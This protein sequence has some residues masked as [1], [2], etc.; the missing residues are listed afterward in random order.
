MGVY[1]CQSY[2]CG[3][4]Y[5]DVGQSFLSLA[6]AVDHLRVLS[7]ANIDL[8]KIRNPSIDDYEDFVA[9]IR[10]DGEKDCLWRDWSDPR[11]DIFWLEELDFSGSLTEMSS[12]LSEMHEAR[13]S[14]RKR[15]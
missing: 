12:F 11:E 2:A 8:I 9:D 15:R 14:L 4:F 5:N 1:L 7:K 6:Q 13:S 3:Y 10:I